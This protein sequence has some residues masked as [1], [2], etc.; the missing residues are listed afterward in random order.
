MYE[1][2]KSGRKYYRNSCVGGKIDNFVQL[3]RKYLGKIM[4]WFTL[5]P[6]GG[7]REGVHVYGDF[8]L[9]EWA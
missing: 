4:S 2:I 5:W 8:L 1:Q 6:L 9:K 7:E 3:G